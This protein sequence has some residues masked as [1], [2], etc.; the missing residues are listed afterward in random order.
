[1]NRQSR[2]PR[3]FVFDAN[4][5]TIADALKDQ[6]VPEDKPAARMSVRRPRT[7]VLEADDVANFQRETGTQP[8]ALPPMYNNPNPNGPPPPLPQYPTT[9]V[10][11]IPPKEGSGEISRPV[12]TKFTAQDVK[13]GNHL[14]SA[15][16]GNEVVENSTNAMIADTFGWDPT[17]PVGYLDMRIHNITFHTEA[18]GSTFCKKYARYEIHIDQEGAK[19]IIFRRYAQL[20][21][22]DKK[23]KKH[24]LLDKSDTNMPPKTGL[25]RDNSAETVSE[26]VVAFQRYFKNVINYPAI[27]KSQYVYI[28]VGPF[29]L[30]DTRPNPNIH[31]W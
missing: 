4:D 25:K 21:Q 22:L 5:T 27:R 24:G 23:L 13:L 7:F 8:P 16:F 1:L 2:R 29:Q 11:F 28:F 20:F 17:K 30:G 26:R 6:Q 18:T 19:W 12:L 15:V 14:S 3:T 31:G 10:L 9:Q